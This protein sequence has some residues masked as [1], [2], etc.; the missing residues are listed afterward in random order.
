MAG[1]LEQFLAK[2][3]G[4]YGKGNSAHLGDRSQYIGASDIAGCPR[5]A[6]LSRQH[7]V[8]HSV[9]TQLRFAWGHLSQELF[10]RLFTTGGLRFEEEV[11]IKHPHNPRIRCHID[12]LFKGKEGRYHVVEKKATKEI[13]SEPYQSWVDQLQFQMGM[14]KRFHPEAR[15]AEIGG[16]VLAAM[17]L[18]KED[19]RKLVSGVK[20]FNSYTPN[21]I[22][23]EHLMKKANHILAAI[24]GKEEARC[25]PSLICGVCPHNSS[26]PSRSFPELEIPQDVIKVAKTYLELNEQRKRIEADLDALKEDLL[27]YAGKSFSGSHDGVLIRS[28]TVKDGTTVDSKKLQ[29]DFPEAFKACSKPK[30]GGT[31]LE[32][33]AVQP[34]Q[35]VEEQKLAA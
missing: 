35:A 9:T 14:L 30:S 20:E 19:F 33:T 29:K 26:C 5:K 22:V 27:K 11:E 2:A 6:V 34:Q 10:A 28:F 21:D 23:F 13:P 1:R 4:L 31:R 17:P 16:S 32:I 24:D 25:E 7:P 3:I 18:P 8:E 15:N 12:F